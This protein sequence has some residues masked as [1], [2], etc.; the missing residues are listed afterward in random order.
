MSM[1]IT[2]HASIKFTSIILCKCTSPKWNAI[3]YL[4]LKIRWLSIQ[5]ESV[6]NFYIWETVTRDSRC[7]CLQVAGLRMVSAH[8]MFR[9]I[10]RVFV[11]TWRHYLDR[12]DRH[13]HSLQTILDS[14]THL[15]S[16][17]VKQFILKRLLEDFY[18][19][20]VKAIKRKGSHPIVD[21][22][23]Q[24]KTPYHYWSGN[25]RAVSPIQFLQLRSS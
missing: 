23:V 25:P 9:A 17:I 5:G 13:P 7:S 1:L 14:P 18:R 3:I 12:S 22:R 2:I 24:A 15:E 19:Y 16:M 8:S 20:I 4:L 11:S 21:S 6:K 10:C